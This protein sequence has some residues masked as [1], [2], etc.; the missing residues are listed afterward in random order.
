MAVKP[1][2]LAEWATGAA[3]IVEPTTPQKQAGWPVDFKPPAQWFNWWMNIVY[4]WV[5]WLDAF[6]SEP[7]TWTGLQTFSN[8]TQFNSSITVTGTSSLSTV[9]IGS[10]GTFQALKKALFD[11]ADSE[12]PAIERVQTAATPH[13]LFQQLVDGSRKLRVYITVDLGLMVTYNARWNVAGSNW[14]RDVASDAWRQTMGKSFKL[15]RAPA[16]GAS[17]VEGNWV[18]NFDTL[19]PFGGGFDALA[20]GTVWYGVSNGVVEAGRHIPQLAWTNLTLSANLTPGA[21]PPQYFKDSTGRV[22]FRG[23]ATAN[24]TIATNTQIATQPV[25]SEI[26]QVKIT[27]LMMLGSTLSGKIGLEFETGGRIDLQT[28]GSV[29]VINGSTISFEELN[30]RSV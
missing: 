24:T 8:A 9:S 16:G 30:Y 17:F 18:K 22:W 21:N 20:T 28:D 19:D 1:T 23:F 26:Q 13:L 2:N 29:T 4:T 15:F 7:H 3:P 12:V 14:V 5:L 25:G 10:T 11:I 6:E 27:T